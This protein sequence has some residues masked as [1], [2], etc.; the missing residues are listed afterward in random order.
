MRDAGYEQ[1][2]LIRHRRERGD[3]NRL[4]KLHQPGLYG[5]HRLIDSDPP[6]IREINCDQIV[7][8]V[9]PGEYG[10]TRYRCKHHNWE[11]LEKPVNG[12]AYWGVIP[13]WAVPGYVMQFNKP[14]TKNTPVLGGG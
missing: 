9:S 13:A 8:V 7:Y 6:V 12:S 4:T 2:G 5:G 10:E 14:S 3:A 1:K 11:R